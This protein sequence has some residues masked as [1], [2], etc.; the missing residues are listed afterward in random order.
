MSPTSPGVPNRPQ[1]RLALRRSDRL[2]PEDRL[3]AL[4]PRTGSLPDSPGGVPFRAAG[5]VLR[6]SRPGPSRHSEILLNSK[7]PS[8]YS[9]LHMGNSF[10]LCNHSVLIDSHLL[11]FH[12]S[13]PCS[14]ERFDSRYSCYRSCEQLQK[15]ELRILSFLQILVQTF[16]RLL[17]LSIYF[18]LN[19]LHRYLVS[20]PCGFGTQYQTTADRSFLRR[21]QNTLRSSI[22]NARMAE[23]YYSIST[24]LGS[25]CGLPFQLKPFKKRHLYYLT[26]TYFSYSCEQLVQPAPFTKTCHTTQIHN[27]LR[28]FVSLVALCF[29]RNSETTMPK[30]TRLTSWD[31]TVSDIA[32]VDFSCTG[33]PHNTS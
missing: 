1:R 11:S 16:L 9:C 6:P 27:P 31:R 19:L 25:P 30:K 7:L 5:P 12:C 24:Y 17:K 29:L 21:I 28:N 4:R 8:T 20:L 23:L 14:C 26:P 32:I 33:K 15:F 13:S 22:S 2:S 3:A 18:G 10:S